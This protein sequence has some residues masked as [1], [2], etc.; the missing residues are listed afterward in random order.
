MI[1]PPQRPRMSESYPFPGALTCY[2]RAERLLTWMGE[3]GGYV[4]IRKDRKGK[5]LGC[6]TDPEMDRLVEA[7]GQGDE[8]TIKGYLTDPRFF[9]IVHPE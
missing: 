5:P 1:A 9:D 4:T 8:E 7:I 2:R 3:H 6:T